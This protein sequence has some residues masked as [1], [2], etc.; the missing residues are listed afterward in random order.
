MIGSLDS[1]MLAASASCSVPISRIYIPGRDHELFKYSQLL[2]ARAFT[3]IVL[4]VSTSEDTI[5]F[6]LFLQHY[7]ILLVIERLTMVSNIEKA[8]FDKCN[9]SPSSP[10]FGNRL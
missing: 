7:S 2:C 1:T 4:F 10:F 3:P 8:T 9:I 5:N 6:L